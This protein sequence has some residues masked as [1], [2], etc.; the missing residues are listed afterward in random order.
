MIKR[1]LNFLLPQAKWIFLFKGAPGPKNPF[2][3]PIHLLLYVAEGEWQCFP[4]FFLLLSHLSYMGLI[5]PLS[6]YSKALNILKVD[7][8]FWISRSLFAL[9]HSFGV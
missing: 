9:V 6:P 2:V 3:V 8:S 4:S 5:E 1:F 7:Q